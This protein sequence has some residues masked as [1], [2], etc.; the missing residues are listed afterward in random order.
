MDFF[1]A[2]DRAK[3]ATWKLLGLYCAAVVLIIMSVY[4]VTL[5][6]LGY[7]GGEGVQQPW[8]PVLFFIVTGFTLIL[9][10]SGTLFRIAQLRKGG[11]AVA[12]M[13]GGRR[14]DAS[15]TDLNE[16]QLINVVEEMSIASG[17]P[18]PDIYLLDN[19]D[20][21]NAFA[22]GFGTEDAAVGVTKGAIEQLDRDE[23]QGVIAHEFSHILNSDM[24]LNVRLIALLAGILMIGQIGQFLFFT[25]AHSRSRNSKGQNGIVII[26][27]ALVVVGYI[28]L[29]FGRLIQA[30]ISRQREMLADASSVQFTRNPEGIASA[31]YQIGESSG[32]FQSTSHASDMNHMCFTEAVHMQLAGMLASHPPLDERINAIDPGLL[33]RLRN[34][35][36]DNIKPSQATAAESPRK[37]GFRDIA[38]G[39]VAPLAGSRTSAVAPNTR[40]SE[41]AGAV[42]PANEEY[43]IQLLR[44]VPDNFRTLLYTRTGAIQFCYSLIFHAMSAAERESALEDAQATGV[45]AFQPELIERFYPTLEALGDAIR[46]PALELAMPALRKLAPGERE[47]LEQTLSQLARADGR[48]SLFEFALLS[49]IRCH[50]APEGRK[51][52]P[53]RFRRFADVADSLGILL[54]LAARSATSTPQDAQQCYREAIAGFEDRTVDLGP[55]RETVTSQNLVAALTRLRGLSPLLKPAIIDACGH[56]VLRDNQVNVREYEILRLVADQLD[57]PMPPLPV[58]A[59]S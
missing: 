26:G 5:L 14:L 1:E 32:Y 44:Q 41:S 34:R 25:S 10:V 27:L 9:I 38:D 54:S 20:T 39:L 42:S 15:S 13:L 55:L 50:L 45:L 11:S 21:I 8:Q 24:R 6:L 48:V 36:R 59:A 12:E 46:L 43:A 35:G 58:T 51:A 4:I 19:E 40:L 53:V 49:F 56:C 57:C 2:Q 28:G 22:A 18:V 3:Q 23:L 16:R 37:T 29:F 7:A 33:V 30:A 17:L 31:L 52:T 47:G